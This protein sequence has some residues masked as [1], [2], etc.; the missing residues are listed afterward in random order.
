M[1]PRRRRRA[2]RQRGP[3]DRCMSSVRRYETESGATRTVRAACEADLPWWPAVPG[4]GRNGRK[5]RSND[6]GQ[7]ALRH[8]RPQCAS[9]V[10]YTKVQ[11]TA[12]KTKHGGEE[13]R[14]FAPAAFVVLAA[15]QLT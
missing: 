3:A 2:A 11:V 4:S 14:P 6:Y 13:G 10:T 7:R 1:G 9:D 5:G 8:Y 15:R 12:D